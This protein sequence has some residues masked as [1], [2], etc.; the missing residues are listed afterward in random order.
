[1]PVEQI[2]DVLHLVM[3]VSTNNTR[4]IQL[5]E[6]EVPVDIKTEPG[7]Q[8]HSIPVC[9]NRCWA[10][11]M[12]SLQWLKHPFIGGG[13]VLRHNLGWSQVVR[14]APLLANWSFP[15]QTLQ[16]HQHAKHVPHAKW[17]TILVLAT[18]ENSQVCFV[19][20][21]G[22]FF[23]IYLFCWYLRFNGCD[24]CVWSAIQVRCSHFNERK[25]DT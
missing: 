15:W 22:G 18:V 23:G 12:R 3:A 5:A 9:W 25:N 4:E 1:M 6:H 10:L 7:R 19:C 8:G 21:H 20:C 24:V 17:L 11:T 2:D 13:K 16:N 14:S